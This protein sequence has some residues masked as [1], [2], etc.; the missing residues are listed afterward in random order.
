MSTVETP[1]R[2][3]AKALLFQYTGTVA[4]RNHARAVEAVMRHFAPLYGEDP[5]KWGIIGLVHDLDWEKFPE[6]HCSRTT[7]ILRDAGWPEDWVRAIRSHAWGMF[8]DD[9]PEHPME[10]VLYAID[11]LTGLIT[12]TALVRPS[13]SILDMTP[14]SVKKKWK[15]K[16]FAAGANRDVITAGAEMMGMPLDEV[17]ARTIEGMQ[18]VAGEIGLAGDTAAGT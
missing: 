8:T 13:R 4:L 11:E 7:A 17:I 2:E 1:T 5:E 16:S 14:K 10:K 3:E 6:E 12:A 15:E 9:K 18:T